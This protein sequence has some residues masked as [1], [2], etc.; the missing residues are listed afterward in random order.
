MYR[1]RTHLLLPIFG[2]MLTAVLGVTASQAQEHKAINLAPARGLPFSDGIVAGNTLYIAGQEGTGEGDKLVSGGIAAETKAALGNI[3]K[4]VKAAG[5]EMKDIVSVTVYL[6]D[7]HD[8]P[9]MNTVY[10]SV[11]PDP[12]PARATMQ[13][14]ALVN[15]A[16]VEIAAIAVKQ[17]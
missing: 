12:K 17:K 11:L 15:G 2:V 8:F 1:T 7:I 16:K 14:A 5:F 9:E 13:A 3:E 6:S 10:K 4:V